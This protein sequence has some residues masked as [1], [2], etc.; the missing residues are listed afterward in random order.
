LICARW[1]DPWNT[2]VV[3][4]HLGHFG[5]WYEAKCQRG[6]IRGMELKVESDQGGG[7]D[8]A[9]NRTRADCIDGQ[10]LEPSSPTNWGTYRGMKTCPAGSAV[11]GAR[12]RLERHLG[13]GQD[14]T[15]M[16]GLEIACCAY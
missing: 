12:I 14:D 8:T 3:R 6:A 9:A 4:P 5:D 15:S 16:N 10:R 7:D 13:E 2:G 1:N 11:C